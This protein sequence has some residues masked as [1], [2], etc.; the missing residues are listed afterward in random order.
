MNPEKKPEMGG[1][2]S[3][4]ELYIKPIDNSI[5]KNISNRKSAFIRIKQLFGSNTP[6]GI[7]KYNFTSSG[8]NNSY[9][10]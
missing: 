7:R 2:Q 5:V 3:A 9:T 10:D 4:F 6:V 8:L 1:P